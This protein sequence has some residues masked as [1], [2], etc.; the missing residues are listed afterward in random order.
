MTVP[1]QR[2]RHRSHKI[3]PRRFVVEETGLRFAFY[4]RMSTV[5]YQDRASSSRWQHDYADDL[6]DGYGR[7]VA[8]FFGEGVSRRIAWPDRPEAARLL[9]AVTDPA[10]GFDA[11]AVGKFD[12]AFYGQQLLHLAPILQQQRCRIVAVRSLRAGRLRGV[13]T[14]AYTASVDIHPKVIIAD[15]AQVFFGSENFSQLIPEQEPG[16]WLRHDE[17]RHHHPGH[18]H[19]RRRLEPQECFGRSSRWNGLVETDCDAQGRGDVPHRIP[20]GQGTRP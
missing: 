3:C 11:I 10:R 12:R 14:Y 17:Y 1:W 9:T 2:G 5:E 19:A 13:H 16:T 8:E 7:I 6:I 4:G 20:T 18:R 15:S